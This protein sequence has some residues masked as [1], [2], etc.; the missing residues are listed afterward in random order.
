MSKNVSLEKIN[1]IEEHRSL[2]MWRVLSQKF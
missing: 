1:I 2:L